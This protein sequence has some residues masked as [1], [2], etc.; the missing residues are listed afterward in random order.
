YKIKENDFKEVLCSLENQTVRD[1]ELILVDNGNSWDLE[2]LVGRC[3]LSGIYFKLKRNYG[4]NIGRNIGAHQA[5]GDILIFLDD[6]GLPR[7]DFVAGH[8]EAH[9][10]YNILAAR[11]KIA[12]RTK[13]VYNKI[14]S[15]YDLGSQSFPYLVNTEG[16][17]SFG[18]EMFLSLSGVDER[19]EGA[20]GHEGAEITYR[21][22]GSTGDQS[23]AIYY[24]RAVIRHNYARGLIHYLKKQIRHKKYQR[25][26]KKENPELFNFIKSYKIK[27]RTPLRLS[28][29]DRIKIRLI[30][31][32]EKIVLVF[33]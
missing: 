19:L 27:K 20:G 8:L 29:I 3:R 10:R 4:L 32:T 12:P 24:P 15:H 33:S 14:Q 7:E 1:F 9:Q 13:T 25:L 22:V 2:S 16:N 18:R 17:S 26:L 21:I 23:K 31:T 5:K 28:L 11:G 6:D 30:K